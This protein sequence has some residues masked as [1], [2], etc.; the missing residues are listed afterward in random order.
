MQLFESSPEEDNRCLQVQQGPPPVPHKEWLSAGPARRQ[1]VSCWGRRSLGEEED[2]A[3]NH[4]WGL[5]I[6]LSLYTFIFPPP[7]REGMR[8][9]LG[10]RREEAGQAPV[11]CHGLCLVLCHGRA[12]TSAF[13]VAWLWEGS[14]FVSLHPGGGLFVCWGGE[15]CLGLGGLVF[16]GFFA[17]FFFIV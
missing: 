17:A 14:G 7:V 9:V 6:Y 15:A 5:L 16:G 4:G 10:G 2:S 3:G 8:G 12:G 13:R 1:A 11:G